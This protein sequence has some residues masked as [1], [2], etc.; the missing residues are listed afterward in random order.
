M[1]IKSILHSFLVLSCALLMWQCGGEENLPGTTVSGQIQNASNMTLHLDR[2]GLGQSANTVVGKTETDGAGN[3]TMNFPE[4]VDPGVYRLR[5][6]QQKMNLILEEGDNLQ[7]NGELANLNRYNVNVKGSKATDVYVETIQ[8]LLAREYKGQDIR[9]LVDTT[10]HPLTAMMLANQAIGLNPKF[11]DLHKK[12]RDKAAEAYPNM[13]AVQ[14]YTT[15][16]SNLE[17]QTQMVNASGNIMVGK[18]APDI[19]LPSPN[20]KEYKLS[21]LKGQVVLLDFWASW[22][23]PCRRENP[24]VVKVYNDYKD[25]GFTVYSVSLDG[26]DSRTKTR[27]GSEEQI[28]AQM[29]RSKERWKNAIQQDGLPW[30]Y[31]VSDLKKWESD[32]ARIYGVRS[33]PKTFL[34][35]REGNIAAINLRGADAIEAALQD[36]I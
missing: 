26:L 27:L 22:C 18:P 20:G 28:S 23:G 8:K 32:P 16:I 33:I 5:V 15:F 25:K 13:E 31:H 12:A 9:N 1:N 6:G 7:V 10:N 34:I 19:T 30:E 21:D 3:F 24:N 2:V 11:I 14:Q 29:E 17:K 35:D 4:G 36:L